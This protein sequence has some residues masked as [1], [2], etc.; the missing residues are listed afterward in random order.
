MYTSH[1]ESPA[2]PRAFACL[3]K[4]TFHFSNITPE[5]Q[6]ANALSFDEELTPKYN[7]LVVS[8]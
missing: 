5:Q 6:A 1:C 7:D 3:Q 2:R 4:I 8:K